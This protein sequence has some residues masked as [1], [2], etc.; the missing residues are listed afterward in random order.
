MG[1]SV[2]N[3]LKIQF[4]DLLHQKSQQIKARLRP[5]VNIFPLVGDIAAYDGVGDIEAR[6]VVGRIQPVVFQDIEHLRRKIKRRRFE[7]TIPVD[8]SDVRGSLLD[9]SKSYAQACIFAIE[10][11]FDRVVVESMFSDVLTGRDF[12]NTVTAA[13][14]GVVTVDATSGLTYDKLLEIKQNFIDSDVGNDMPEQFVLGIAGDEHTDLMSE[15][16]LT[17]GDYTHEYVV[18][19]GEIQKAVGFNLIRFA[20]KAKKPMLP[21]SSGSNI[22][23]SFAMSTRGMAVGISAEPKLD[24]SERK[25]YVETNQVQVIIELGAVRTEGKLIQK[26][27]TTS[28]IPG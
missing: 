22:R 14:D 20:G 4:T 13:Q 16:K 21:V 27:N 28:S 15:T 18:A 1:A 12:E 10:R 11:V 6:E 24:I 17:S 19:N 8:S 9:P 25:D 3:A 2:D 26:I 7:V 5:F 23:S